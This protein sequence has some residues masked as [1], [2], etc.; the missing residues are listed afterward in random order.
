MREWMTQREENETKAR[1]WVRIK[2]Q[3]KGKHEPS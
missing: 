1:V 3:N 2:R